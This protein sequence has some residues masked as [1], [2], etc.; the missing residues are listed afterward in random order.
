[1]SAHLQQYERRVYFDCD[2]G[3]LPALYYGDDE[4]NAPMYDYVRLFQSDARA[5]RLLLGAETVNADYT[6]RPDDRPWSERHPA[7]LWTAILAAV[8]VLGGIALRSIKG[9]AS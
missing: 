8:A 1:M 5:E 6:G 3:I 9:A 4:L 7:I 2:A